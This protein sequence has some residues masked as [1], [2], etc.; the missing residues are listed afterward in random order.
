MPATRRHFLTAAGALAAGSACSTASSKSGGSAAPALPDVYG[1]LGVKTVIN[2]RGT[3]TILGGTVMPPE[4]VDAM[5][6]ASHHYISLPEL[7][8]AAGEHIAKLIGVPGAMISCG[9]ASAITCG[10]AACMTRGDGEKLRSLPDVSGMPYEI[11]QQKAHRSGY[12]AQMLLCGAKTVWVETAAEAEKAIN[13]RTAMM[14]FLNKAD[15][16]GQIKRDEFIRIAKANKIPILN[17]AAADVPPKERL[18]GYVDEG[19]DLVIFSGGKGLYGPQA[20]GLLL[21]DKALVEAARKAIS[22]NGGIGRGMKVGKEEI[23]GLVAA[24]ERYLTMDH[25]ADR[26]AM[27]HRA[28]VVMSKLKAVD[29]VTTEIEIPE[30]ANHV[31]HVLVKWDAAAKGVTAKEGYDKLLA[32]DPAVAVSPNG[33]GGFTISMWTLKPGEEEIVGDSLVKL[34]S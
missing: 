22:P 27:D 8:V 19:F 6:A 31:P 15:P 26:K 32:M 33:D 4:V 21:G 5:V 7:Q 2:G 11:I 13:E 18:K 3:V 17:D 10:T 20:S 29:G 12:E 1:K 28:E 25:D 23:C 16:H 9:A 34:F 30:I 14:F 24:V